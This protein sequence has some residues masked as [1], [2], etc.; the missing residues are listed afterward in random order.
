MVGILRIKHKFLIIFSLFLW[1]LI[2]GNFACAKFDVV[3]PVYGKISSEFGM[4]PDPFTGKQAF[5]SGIDIAADSGTPV[6]AIQDGT[7]IYSGVKGGYGN[8]VMIDHYYPDVPQIPRLQTLYGHNS[9]LLVNVGD[10]VKRG[11]VVAYV[12]S[13]GRSKGPH[14][15]FEVRYN[16][17]YV[18][19]MDYLYKLPSYLDYVVFARSK[20]RYTSYNSNSSVNYQYKN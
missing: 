3:G 15:H 6:Y 9:T 2:Q 8:C 17:M 1:L 18:N 4:R 10:T 19:P 13:T 5:H 11:Q 7:V 14:L 12:G 20:N 16:D